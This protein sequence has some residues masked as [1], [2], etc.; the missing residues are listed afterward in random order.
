MRCGLAILAHALLADHYFSG[1]VCFEGARERLGGE[2]DFG[3]GKILI[4]GTGV[5]AISRNNR[6][7]TSAVKIAAS[8]AKPGSQT[9]AIP[10][11]IHCTETQT[12]TSTRKPSHRVKFAARQS[13]ASAMTN[14]AKNSISQTGASRRYSETFSSPPWESMAAITIGRFCE[15][16]CVAGSAALRSSRKMNWSG[17]CCGNNSSPPSIKDSAE[18]T[19]KPLIGLSCVTRR[20]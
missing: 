7:A 12:L 6:E 16:A 11:A 14:T 3:L 13:S 17:A 5:G 9:D 20:P 2:V 4:V 10:S 18:I 1:G 15:N 8:T 19:E